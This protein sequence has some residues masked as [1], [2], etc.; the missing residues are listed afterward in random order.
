M[1]RLEEHQAVHSAVRE[2]SFVAASTG[3][4]YLLIGG[5]PRPPAVFVLARDTA[6]LN[7]LEAFV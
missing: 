2:F 6:A 4:R 1:P 3:D 7:A 5:Q